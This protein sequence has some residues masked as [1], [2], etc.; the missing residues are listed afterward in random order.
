MSLLVPADLY[1]PALRLEGI[2]RVLGVPPYPGLVPGVVDRS[3]IERFFD[4]QRR[5]H[6]DLALQPVDSGEVSNEVLLRLGAAETV[7]CRVP[8]AVAPDHWIPFDPT[9]HATLR[10][11]DVLELTGIPADGIELEFPTRPDDQA[12]FAEAFRIARSAF[13]GFNGGQPARAAGRWIAVHLGAD[14]PNRG[15]PAEYWAGVVDVLLDRWDLAGVMLL[16]DE[17]EIDSS[18]DYLASTRQLDQVVNLAGLLSI[19]GLAAAIG[20]AALLLGN[21]SSPIWL[22]QAAGTPSVAAVVGQGHPGNGPLQRAYHRAVHLPALVPEVAR[23]LAGDDVPVGHHELVGAAS[24]VLRLV[25]ETRDPPL[26]VT[27]RSDLSVRVG[28]MQQLPDGTP[29]IH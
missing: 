8:G 12:E 17:R 10:A 5:A 22:A 24:D 16:A 21:D 19:G 6:Y 7:G 23:K 4:D 2:H 13:D 14:D 3:R 11:L 25:W 27:P 28:T 20:S 29:V 9:Q 26:L 1:D 18:M 15:W